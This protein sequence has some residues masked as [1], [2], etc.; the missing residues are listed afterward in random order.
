MITH[1]WGETTGLRSEWSVESTTLSISVRN[2]WILSTLD[3][4]LVSLRRGMRRI[5]LLSPFVDDAISPLDELSRDR[6]DEHG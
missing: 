2:N 1:N 6:I 5:L 4:V 3:F